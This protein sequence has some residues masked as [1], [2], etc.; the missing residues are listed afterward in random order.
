[1]SKKEEQFVN[2]KEMRS[3]R[4]NLADICGDCSEFIKSEMR[5]CGKKCVISQ[6]YKISQ[7]K[8]RR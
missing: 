1:M 6:L 3:S 7:K 2:K 5:Q 8:S 4:E